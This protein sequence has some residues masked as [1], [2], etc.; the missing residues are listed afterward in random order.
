M[1]DDRRF[2]TL[3]VEWLDD[4]ATEQ[5]AAGLH[6]RSMVEVRRTQPRA[7]WHVALRGGLMG[8]VARHAGR[9]RRPLA[10]LLVVLL[11]ALALVAAAIVGG[12]LVSPRLPP[13]YG[14]AENG[15]LSF[16]TDGDIWV[17]DPDGRNRRP[18]IDDPADDGWPL[19]SPDGARL[20]FDRT[21]EDGRH[22]VMVAD[23]DGR[24]ARQVAEV[25]LPFEQWTWTDWAPDSRSLVVMWAAQGQPALVVLHTDG[26]PP[27]ALD[28]GDLVPTEFASWRPPDGREII[29][30]ADDPSGRRGIYAI[31]ADGS[32][33]RPI[34]EPDGDSS[35][36]EH[37]F[38]QP[39]LSPDGRTIAFSNWE[40]DEQGVNGMYLHLRD[41]TT[42]EDRPISLDPGWPGV[43]MLPRYTPDG[44]SLV[45]ESGPRTTVPRADS[46]LVIAPIDGSVPALALGPAYDGGDDGIMESFDISPDGSTVILDLAGAT[47]LIDTA[48]GEAIKAPEYLPNQPSWQRR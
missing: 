23:S 1:I 40:A 26:R 3:L 45:F 31:A 17:V 6:E 8:S 24:N 9:A 39:G 21:R 18:L 36:P 33:R 48:T 12:R 4:A 28:I 19:Y 30:E 27:T 43:G 32:A 15:L 2:E 47:W 41:L 46:Q 38:Q 25:P 5:G 20:I 11:L 29:F 7:A 14:P 16:S 10:Y 44:R 42:G 22:V 37:L 13:P 35:H 34:G